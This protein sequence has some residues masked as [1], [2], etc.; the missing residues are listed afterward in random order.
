LIYELN[1]VGKEFGEGKHRS[2]AVRNVT[3][4]ISSGE[5][6][7][8]IGPSGSGKT[9]LFRLLNGS[10]LP[11]SGNLLYRERDVAALSERQLRAMRRK[12]TFRDARSLPEACVPCAQVD[13]C[14]G[15]CAGRRRL[16][17]ELAKPD[18]YC[19]ILR[20]ESKPLTVTM[21]PHRDLPKSE[22]ACTT[23]VMGREIKEN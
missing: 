13:A 20:G 14:H 7:A 1:A 6:I 21:A 3:L 5:R 10:L 23:I 9:T 4:T 15:G 8:L 19:P 17:H 2:V 12:E 11:S 22:S 18:F 16:H